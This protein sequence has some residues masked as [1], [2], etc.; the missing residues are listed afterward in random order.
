M[1]NGRSTDL[2]NVPDAVTASKATAINPAALSQMRLLAM[3][4]AS[5]PGQP[6]DSISREPKEQASRP[7]DVTRDRP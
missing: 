7:A 5:L 4:C 6:A 3:S 2:A 1:T